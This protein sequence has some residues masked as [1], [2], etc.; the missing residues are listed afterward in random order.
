MTDS[1]K[2]AANVAF[3]GNKDTV[4][5]ILNMINELEESGELQDC[6]GIDGPFDSLQD[7]LK[8]RADN[9]MLESQADSE[10]KND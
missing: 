1:E 2:W 9:L 4:K 7:L 3:V 10:K 8:R 6:T 5:K